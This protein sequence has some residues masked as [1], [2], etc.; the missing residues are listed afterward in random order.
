MDFPFAPTLDDDLAKLVRSFVPTRFELEI[1]AK[2]HF[3]EVMKDRWMW[4]SYRQACSFGGRK[5]S[6]G[7]QRLATIED[8]IG[9]QALDRA[10]APVRKEWDKSFEHLA[11]N[12][13]KHD[14]LREYC[15]CKRKV[16]SQASCVFNML[17]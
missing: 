2:H 12:K 4:E 8:F 16:L 7:L 13:C 1:I 6:F 14:V 5:R 17:S 11:K 9:E 15:G 10:I 3:D